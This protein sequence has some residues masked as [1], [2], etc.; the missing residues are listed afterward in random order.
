M[1]I[2]T[3]DKLQILVDLGADIT[4]LINIMIVL[5]T[6]DFDSLCDDLVGQYTDEGKRYNLWDWQRL[7]SNLEGIF[8]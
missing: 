4:T 3:D 8:A 2:T 6:D 1:P 7:K 5:G